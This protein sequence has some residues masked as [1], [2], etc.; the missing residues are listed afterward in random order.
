MI[1][2]L[3]KAEAAH[4]EQVEA[5]QV[6]AD[7]ALSGSAEKATATDAILYHLRVLADIRRDLDKEAS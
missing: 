1:E 6:V 5:W 2:T 4:K 7:T 3:K